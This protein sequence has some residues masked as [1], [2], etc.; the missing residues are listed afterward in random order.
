[1]NMRMMEQVLAPG[2]QDAEKTYLRSKMFRI[3][4]NLKKSGSTG[5]K[6]E[7]VYQLLILKR[8]RRQRMWNGKHQMYVRNC[9]EFLLPGGQP[10]FPGSV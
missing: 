4:G 1:M 9:Q 10:L 8:Q 2:M 5:S 3:G 6:Q 7:R